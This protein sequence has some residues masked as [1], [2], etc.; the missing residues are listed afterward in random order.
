MQK[1]YAS[2][3]P[4]LTWIVSDVRDLKELPDNKFDIVIDKACLDALMCDVKDPWCPNEK[5]KT[6]VDQTLR[7]VVRVMKDR[8]LSS[9]ISVGFQQPHFRKPYLNANDN[10]YGWENDMEVFPIEIGFGY[11]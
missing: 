6:D 9:F 2:T 11:F 4:A 3:H 7:S 8:T 1:K 5:T 10:K